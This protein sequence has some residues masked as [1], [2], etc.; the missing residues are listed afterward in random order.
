MIHHV[1]P[2]TGRPMAPNCG[3]PRTVA[4]RFNFKHRHQDIEAARPFGPPGLFV[5]FTGDEASENRRIG[6]TIVDVWLMAF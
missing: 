4:A 6:V 3:G 1:D 2:E 5:G